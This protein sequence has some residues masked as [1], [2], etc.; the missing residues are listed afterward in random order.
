M[1]WPGAE[2]RFPNHGFPDWPMLGVEMALFLKRSILRSALLC[3]EDLPDGAYG[4]Q[5]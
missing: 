1:R 5:G 4:A 3:V 2:G